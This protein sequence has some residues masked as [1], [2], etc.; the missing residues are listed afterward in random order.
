MADNLKYT[1]TII[2]GGAAAPIAG[3]P[4]ATKA[5]VLRKRFTYSDLTTDGAL[6]MYLPAGSLIIGEFFHVD[7]AF[8]GTAGDKF[9]VTLGSGGTAILPNTVTTLASL[10]DDAALGNT[11]YAKAKT[12]T[13]LYVDFTGTAFTAGAGELIILFVPCDPR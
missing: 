12:K 6:G 5:Q 1:Q 10:S 4:V 11:I 2:N 3:A 8:T 9:A 13:Q 7:T